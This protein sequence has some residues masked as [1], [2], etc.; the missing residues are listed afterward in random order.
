MEMYRE[1][2]RWIKTQ[3]EEMVALLR[4][5]SEI[6]SGSSNLEGLRAMLAA[7]KEAFLPL[8]GTV[9]EIPLPD[10]TRINRQGEMEHSPVGAALRIQKRP[11]APIKVLLVGHYDTVYP[12]GSPFQKTEFLDNNTLH[13]PGTADMKGGLVIMLKALEALEKSPFAKQ[14]GWEVLLNPDEEI[15][16]TSSHYLLRES[17]G[18]NH[19]GL[20]FEPPFP[21]GSLASGRKGSANFTIVARGRAAHAG[22]DFH[23][24]HNAITA[25]ARFLLAVDALNAPNEGITVNIGHIEGGGPT[26][27]VPDL[28]ICRLNIRVE[29]PAQFSVI[30]NKIT[31]AAKA[32]C[33]KGITLTVHEHGFRPPKPFDRHHQLLFEALREVANECLNVPLRW[34]PTGGV[35]DGNTLA[36]EG[37]PTIDTLGVVGGNIHTEDEYA[38]LD[39]LTKRAMLVACFL[40][41]LSH[42]DIRLNYS[43]EKTQ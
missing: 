38:H 42:R 11:E 39:S 3:H 13:G 22:R 12:K 43:E 40:M 9:H 35:C 32:E 15:G 16:S 33:E 20:I 37:L 27:I 2:L 23:L 1:H 14:I 36:A 21:D 28:A 18:R 5:W 41:Q 26:N 8:G 30:T 31:T 17:A 10:H 34:N 7:L 25:M 24:G 29:Q 4:K 6:N 19:V